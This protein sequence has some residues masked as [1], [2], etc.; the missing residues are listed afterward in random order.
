M[1]NR[2]YLSQMALVSKFLHIRR[3]RLP[4]TY[5]DTKKS[6]G[7][8]YLD[9]PVHVNVCLRLSRHPW[10]PSGFFLRRTTS[11]QL[12]VLFPTMLSLNSFARNALL[13]PPQLRECL[14][15]S[16][17]ILDLIRYA[18]LYCYCIAVLKLAIYQA[19]ILCPGLN[20]TS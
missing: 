14:P 18:R 12:E 13:M 10:I 20:V 2:P 3:A 5:F 9:V 4:E 11:Y 17:I 6:Q 1:K 19:Q 7:Y 15:I 16:H 8:E